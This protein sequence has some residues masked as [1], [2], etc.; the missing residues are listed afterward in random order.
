MPNAQRHDELAI[1]SAIVMTPISGATWLLLDAS[2]QQAAINTAILVG[3]HLACSHWLSPDLDIDSSIDNR[4]G[5]FGF[6]WKPYEKAIPHRHWLSHSGFSVLLR[7]GYLLLIIA[8]VLLLVELVL[9][10]T[11]L[12][13]YAWLERFVR[14]HPLEIGLFLLGAFISDALHTITDH[15]STTRKRWTRNMPRPLRALLNPRYRR[16]RRRRR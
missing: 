7:L 2:P 10:G 3:S 6:L 4:W 5:I 13:V 16:R 9:A 11:L 14:T 1:I 8:L 12:S 15:I